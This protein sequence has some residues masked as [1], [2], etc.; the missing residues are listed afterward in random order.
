M[1]SATLPGFCTPGCVSRTKSGEILPFSPTDTGI[2]QA[3]TWSAF[4]GPGFVIR[5][6]TGSVAN[7]AN[8]VCRQCVDF[9]T[10]VRKMVENRI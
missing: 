6:I 7:Q 1:T 5:D 8:R 3:V 2:Y 9:T 4:A 10:L